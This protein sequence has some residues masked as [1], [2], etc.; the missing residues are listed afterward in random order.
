MSK[1]DAAEYFKMVQFGSWTQIYYLGTVTRRVLGPLR[2]LTHV[3]RVLFPGGKA[4]GGIK[5][6]API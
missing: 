2:R 5:L 3:C 6:N 4:A 1:E